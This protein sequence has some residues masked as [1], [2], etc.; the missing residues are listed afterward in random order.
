MS[1]TIYMV[2]AKRSAV[3]PRGGAFAHLQPHELGAPLIKSLLAETKIAPT[4]IDHVLLGN[5]LAGGGNV[6]RMVAL[7]AG[8]PEAVPAI[9][10]DSQCCGG[11]DAVQMA[12]HM[13]SAGAADIIL[14][15]GVESFSTAPRRIKRGRDGAP[16]Q[17]Y[18]RPPFSPW[19]ER[20]PDMIAAAAHLAKYKQISRTA[21]EEFAIK[22]HQKAQAAQVGLRSE[23]VAIADVAEDAFTRTL[24]PKLCAKLPLLAGDKDTGLTAATTAVEAD[25]AGLCVLLSEKALNDHPELKPHAIKLR[26]ALSVGSDP[27]LPGLAPIAAIEKL[28][29]QLDLSCANIAIVEMMEAFAAQA[30]ACLEATDLPLARTNLGGGALARGHP[31]GASGAINLVRLFHELQRAEIGAYG[32]AAIAGAGGLGAALVM[33]K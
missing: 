27:A 4:Q 24:S 3:V 17:E 32:L 28:L 16:D 2:A 26:G 11:V 21:Q 19:P 7:A 6:A 18:H 30:M 31:I 8:L 1:N 20:D 10:L 14:A 23:I 25:G 15:G 33:Q 5:G 29:H 9:T 22:S 12:M 13:L